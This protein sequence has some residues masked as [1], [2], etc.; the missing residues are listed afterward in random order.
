M[1][2]V[3]DAVSSNQAQIIQEGDSYYIKDLNSSNGTFLDG[4]KSKK[5]C[6]RTARSRL[7]STLVFE[8]TDLR[9]NKRKMMMTLYIITGLLVVAALVKVSQPKDVAGMHI[10]R[11]VLGQQGEWLQASN[12]Y[13]I[14]QRR[15]QSQC[16]RRLD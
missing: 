9:A 4:I 14:A 13:Q 11:A 8:R 6:C 5:I 12:E 15:S 3:D 2:L 16:L 10:A 1:V 7:A